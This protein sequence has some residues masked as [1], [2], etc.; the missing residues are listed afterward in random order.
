[1]SCVVLNH[2]TWLIRN[3]RGKEPLTN[4]GLDGPH[5]QR[6]FGCGDMT[7]E[8]LVNSP[9]FSRVTCLSSGTMGLKV[10]RSIPGIVDRVEAS[11]FI[12]CM[13]QCRLGF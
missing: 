9:S 13:Y 2:G 8:R 1:M 6:G 7:T 10:L 11:S 3:I 5:I 4:H 12:S